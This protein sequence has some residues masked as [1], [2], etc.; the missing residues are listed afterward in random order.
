MLLRD[1]RT[2]KVIPLVGHSGPITSVHFDRSGQRVVTSSEDNGARIWDARI[3]ATLERLVGHTNVVNDAEF[4]PDG[5]WLVTA[6]LPIVARFD[7]DR[8]IVTLA[9]DGKVRAWLCDFCGT[10]DQLVRLANARLAQTGR[11][12]TPDEGRRAF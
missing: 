12:F 2:G 5:R 3:G 1:L 7:G 8:R 4:S 10:L 11:S 6:G 9:R